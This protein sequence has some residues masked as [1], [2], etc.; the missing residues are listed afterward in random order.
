MNNHLHFQIG[1][2]Q[3]TVPSSKTYFQSFETNNERWPRKTKQLALLLS[4]FL[5][6]HSFVE[7]KGFLK[8][9]GND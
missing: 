7:R 6:F 5:N 8:Q 3:A 9:F 4:M 2:Q 1:F